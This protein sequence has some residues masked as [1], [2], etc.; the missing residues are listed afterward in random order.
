M[1]VSGQPGGKDDGSQPFLPALRDPVRP[2]ESLQGSHDLLRGERLEVV[3]RREGAHRV[4]A[5]WGTVGCEEAFRHLRL[6]ERKHDGEAAP[7]Q[8]QALS[9]KGLQQRY[10]A[11]E[12]A[13]V[14]PSQIHAISRPSRVQLS[15]PKGQVALTLGC[16]RSVLC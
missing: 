7:A 15:R 14:N 4:V 11:F 1:A 10:D 12:L 5:A 13:P 6:A 3:P 2:L 16:R 9:I 8:L